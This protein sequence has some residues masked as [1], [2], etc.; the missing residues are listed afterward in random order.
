M[1]ERDINISPN[2]AVITESESMIKGDEETK[3]GLDNNTG[4]KKSYP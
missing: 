1:N 2:A 3:K 4:S